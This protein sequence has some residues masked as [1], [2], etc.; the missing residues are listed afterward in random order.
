M[1]PC[2]AEGRKNGNTWGDISK[3]LAIGCILTNL[4][5]KKSHQT[6]YLETQGNI[7]CYL[8]NLSTKRGMHFIF[9]SSDGQSFIVSYLSRIFLQMINWGFICLNFCNLKF[10]CLP[11]LLVM[12]LVGPGWTFCSRKRD[13]WTSWCGAPSGSTKPPTTTTTWNKRKSYLRRPTSTHP[14]FS[15]GT[16]NALEFW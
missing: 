7:E 1:F 5:L 10:H 6:V 8:K 14:E 4:T 3:H 13:T 11:A 16:T 9:G 2:V 15:A 12:S